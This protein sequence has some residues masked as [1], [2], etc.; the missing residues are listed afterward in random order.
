MQLHTTVLQRFK[1]TITNNVNICM[2]GCG[3]QSAAGGS[4]NSAHGTLTSAGGSSVAVVL[5]A[6][7]YKS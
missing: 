5:E 2:R 7:N 3:R 1:I 4:I 6:I